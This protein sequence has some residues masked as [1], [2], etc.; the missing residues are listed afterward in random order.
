MIYFILLFAF[1]VRLIS[2][3][4]SLWFDEAINITY[5]QKLGLL[6]YLSNY[7]T[8]D[9]HPPLHFAIL[10][11][12][13]HIFG[14]SEIAARLPSLLF[15]V[16]TVF[17]TFLIGRKFSKN[18]GLIAAFLLSVAPLH[19]YYSQ[20]ARPYSLAAFAV[21]L[22]SYYFLNSFKK[23]SNI[24]VGLLL[25]SSMVLYSD[26][27]AYFIFPAQALYV[28]LNHR[29]KIFAYFKSLLLS[30][31]IFSPW[32]L[33]F[34]NQ[35]QTGLKTS[36]QIEGWKKVVGGATFKEPA[37]LW[38]KTLI[39]R[40]TFENK[41]IYLFLVG[42]SSLLN[43]FILAKL[44]KEIKDS[45][46]FVFWFLLPPVFAFIF[47]F[48]I[49]VFSY[50]RFIYILPAFY[51]LLAMGI[52]K[53]GKKLKY[54]VLIFILLMQCLFSFMYLFD[55]N[56]HREDWKVAVEFTNSV[57]PQDTVVLFK[58]SEVPPPF[59]YY[60]NSQVLSLGAF[61]VIPAKSARDVVDLTSILA[62]KKKIFL[63]D[64]LKDITDPSGFLE[65]ALKENGYKLVKT[66][67]F[68]G[69][70]FVYYYEAN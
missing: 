45:N 59:S 11:V 37:L 6:E 19:V 1:A 55:P 20:E 35:I 51:I 68:R 32:L 52:E 42:I 5:A 31:I 4:Q 9:F 28:F 43:L 38:I 29:K 41:L 39:G 26:Y 67:D 63:F 8:G 53:F 70:G 16:G 69:V 57:S 2:L 10:W 36:E 25:S 40:I 60:K 49:P 15:G 3:N 47:S 61:R 44:K 48:F 50:F 34:P 24:S 22:C 33:V 56:Y 58:N 62:G 7:L 27:V 18:I 64:Y 66:Y 14:S 12:W 46:Y 17:I 13:T 54:L 23:P 30:L 21:A 65:R